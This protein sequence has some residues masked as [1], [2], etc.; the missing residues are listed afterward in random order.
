VNKSGF[1]VDKMKRYLIEGLYEKI[2]NGG[3]RKNVD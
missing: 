3:G 1:N 2:K